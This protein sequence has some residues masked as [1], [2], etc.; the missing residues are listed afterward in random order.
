MRGD[1][2]TDRRRV[3]R[4]AGFTSE[5]RRG[6]VVVVV[7]A[8][9]SREKRIRKRVEDTACRRK[10]K[11]ALQHPGSSYVDRRDSSLSRP[12]SRR[13]HLLCQPART[14]F[15]TMSRRRYGFPCQ[16]GL[17]NRFLPLPLFISS[18]MNLI[19]RFKNMN[20]R[21]VA[22]HANTMNEKSRINEIIKIFA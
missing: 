11:P 20:Y 7:A 2:D 16:I 22:S 10:V 19:K 21:E 6:T 18:V 4:T 15:R 9:R 17:W 13:M 14:F 1:I 8:C 5:G 12:W 3:E